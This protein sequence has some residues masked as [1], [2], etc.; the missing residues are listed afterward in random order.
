MADRPVRSDAQAT[1]A[2]A[3]LHHQSRAG[4]GWHGLCFSAL[5]FPPFAVVCSVCIPEAVVSGLLP[6]ARDQRMLVPVGAQRR[7]LLTI[8]SLGH[9]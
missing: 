9:V 1:S 4:L 7:M 6:L 5:P 3:A 8:A 2:A